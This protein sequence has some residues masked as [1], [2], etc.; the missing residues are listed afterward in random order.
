MNNAETLPSEL[1]MAAPPTIPQARS[2]MFKQ[3]S[4]YTQYE[5]GKGTKVRINIPRLQRTYLSKDSYLRFRL[6]VEVSCT[7]NDKPAAPLWLER[8]GAVAL[9]DR[10]EV[11]DYLGGTLLE[12]VNNLPNLMTILNDI[13]T[14]LDAYDTKLEATRGVTGTKITNSAFNSDNISFATANTGMELVSTKW[15]N[16]TTAADKSNTLT[17]A[18]VTYEFAIPIPSF[19][20][21]FSDKFVPLHN[22]FSI[23]LFLNNIQ[24]A[25]ISYD[26]TNNNAT[27][28]TK[29]FLTNFELCAQVMELGN[30]AENLVLASNGGG[31]LIIPSRFY[32]YF[33]DLVKGADEADQSST[34][35][36]DLNLNVVSLRNLRFG[37]RPL[38]YQNS[39]KYPQYSHRIRNYL[40]S[41]NFQYGSSYLPELAGISCRSTVLPLSPNGYSFPYVNKSNTPFKSDSDMYKQFG[42]TQA[43]AELLKTGHKD[44]WS[45]DSVPCSINGPEYCVD[46]ATYDRMFVPSALDNSTIEDVPP[47]LGT[48]TEQAAWCGKFIGGIDLRLSSKDVISGIDTNGL[49]VR[50]N[51]TFD[52]DHLK[53]MTNAVLD[54]YCEHDAFVQIVPG[55]A[56]TVTF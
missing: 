44:H 53:D 25:V 18:Y 40:T 33:T 5:M 50:L 45:R 37:M 54:V 17:T 10:I 28:V 26:D 38:F 1:R 56:S 49:L 30:D 29:A 3:K 8:V 23:D 6:N 24:N 4:E 51:M 14:P 48:T 31:P 9:F 46:I 12:Q 47:P 21:I 7:K 42:F 55:V 35:G 2:Y 15:N 27:N 52:K 22:G 16:D 34:Y 41:F 20:G 36:M 13:F 32:R 43:F 19:I 11:Y 39:S